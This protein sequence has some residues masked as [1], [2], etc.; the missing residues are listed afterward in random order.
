MSGEESAEGRR[1][2]IAHE[3]LIG[4]WPTLQAWLD[5]RREAEQVRRR[6]EGKAQE[7]DR[8][9]RGSGGLLDEVEQL[10]AERWLE[11]PDAGSLGYSDDLQSLVHDR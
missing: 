3:S 6:L 7:S 4:G 5:E 11:S 9:G 1:A 10:E 8:L 2:D